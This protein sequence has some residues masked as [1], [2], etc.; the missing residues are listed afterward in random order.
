MD[1]EADFAAALKEARPY[2]EL[3]LVE[4]LEAAHEACVQEAFEAGRRLT[5][6]HADVLEAVR[7]LLRHPAVQA[8]R[9]EEGH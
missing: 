1:V 2:L 7:A 6:A 9:E 8:L 5:A 4:D 3:D